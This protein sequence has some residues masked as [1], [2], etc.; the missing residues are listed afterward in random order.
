[1]TKVIKI[2][3]TENRFYKM[4]ADVKKGLAVHKAIYETTEGKIK[5]HWDEWRVTHVKSGYGVLAL[6]SKEDALKCREDLFKIFDWTR[7]IDVEKPPKI[8]RHLTKLKKKYG[9]L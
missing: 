9:V 5:R 3:M 2:A 1:M 4:K 6:Y 7:T 8:E